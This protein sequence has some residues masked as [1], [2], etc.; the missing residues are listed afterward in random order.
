MLFPAIPANT[1]LISGVAGGGISVGSVSGVCEGSATVG[2]TCDGM[3]GVWDGGLV[4][5]PTSS[6]NTNWQYN[7][8]RTGIDYCLIP[9]V[10]QEAAAHEPQLDALWVTTRPSEW[11]KNTEIFRDV[12]SPWHWVQAIG[13]SALLIERK[14]SNLVLQSRQIYS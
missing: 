3:L 14:A 12:F 8:M 5:A 4:Q 2:G 10:E 1:S 6:A 13:L 11:A 9:Q 7:Q